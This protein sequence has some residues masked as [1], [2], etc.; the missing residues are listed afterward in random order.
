LKL[1]GGVAP[2]RSI[3]TLATE[4]FTHWH[5][6]RRAAPIGNGRRRVILWPDTFTNYFQPRVARAGFEVLEA[7]GVE[8]IVPEASLCCGRPLYD[9]G[10]LG[11]AKRLLR[12]VLNELRPYVQASVPVVGLEPSC[13]AV[14]RDELVNLFPHDEDA[15]R[16]AAQSLLLSEFLEQEGFS[17]P[18]LPG[19]AIVQIHC[20]HASVMGFEAEREVLSGLGLD[21]DVL[22]SGCCG[23]A[24]S[25]GFER[26]EKYEVSVRAGE[27]VLLPTVR[28]ANP[29]T[30]IIADGFSCREQIRQGTGRRALHLAEVIRMGLDH[31]DG[32]RSPVTQ[33]GTR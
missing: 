20:H 9:F 13:L 4:T 25:F 16:L 2:E 22:D 11:L 30:M 21:V 14:F 3:P 18:T 12:R 32:E 27:R 26:G 15:K 28:A 8:V 5:R 33:G 19:K 24:G 29:E 1:L 31:H 10:M 23:M 7:A 17:L 6:R